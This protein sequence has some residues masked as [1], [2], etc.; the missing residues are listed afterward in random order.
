VP[1]FLLDLY[2]K[3]EKANLTQA[4]KN[5]LRAILANLAG[6]YRKSVA[7]KV[8]ALVSKTKGKPW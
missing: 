6:D 3:G 2:G 4:E 5:A 8:L 1:V 7:R